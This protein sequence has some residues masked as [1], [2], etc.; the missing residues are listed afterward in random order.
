MLTER[1]K[2][3]LSKIFIDRYIVYVYVCKKKS[4]SLVNEKNFHL[5]HLTKSM[6]TGN[7]SA[8]RGHRVYVALITLVQKPD[9][10]ISGDRISRENSKSP[11]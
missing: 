2:S 3:C 9:F 8:I 7:E 11:S 4:L 6:A 5:I 1:S 10:L